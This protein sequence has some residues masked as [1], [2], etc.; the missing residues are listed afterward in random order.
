MMKVGDKLLPIIGQG[1]SKGWGAGL[2]DQR[3]LEREEKAAH[4]WLVLSQARLRSLRPQAG[5]GPKGKGGKSSNFQKR[6]SKDK[7]EMKTGL[8]VERKATIQG[9]NKVKMLQPI[10]LHILRLGRVPFVWGQYGGRAEVEGLRESS[11]AGASCLFK[12]GDVPNK[13]LHLW[14]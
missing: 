11:E 10:Y 9:R 5:I 12:I 6:S 2:R 3:W 4:S 7:L 1:G 8:P 13:N 14:L